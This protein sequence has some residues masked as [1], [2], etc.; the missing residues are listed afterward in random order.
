MAS[1][2][3]KAALESATLLR[4]QDLSPIAAIKSLREQFGLD[5]SQAKGFVTLAASG[6]SL[7]QQQGLLMPALR[8]L[9]QEMEDGDDNWGPSKIQS[10]L[11]ALSSEK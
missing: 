4:R 7:D 6:V 9:F 3:A 1:A 10:R 8:Q 5:L 2:D 11:N